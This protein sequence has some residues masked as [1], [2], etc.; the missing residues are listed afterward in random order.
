MDPGIKLNGGEGLVHAAVGDVQDRQ[1]NYGER[2]GETA[3]RQRDV[4]GHAGDEAA[5]G[6]DHDED[7]EDLQPGVDLPAI[8]GDEPDRVGD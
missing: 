3:K 8:V 5:E 6:E 4:P 1:Q 2:E 7:G